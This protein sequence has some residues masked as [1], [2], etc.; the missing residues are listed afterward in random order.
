VGIYLLTRY[1]RKVVPF[2]FIIAIGAIYAHIATPLGI[3]VRWGDNS[4][5]GILFILAI[6]ILILSTYLLIVP[7]N[8]KH[9]DN[10][11]IY[12]RE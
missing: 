5:G 6:I 1:W 2:A 9:I 4:D 3:V 8:I 10:K 11:I 7:N 12:K